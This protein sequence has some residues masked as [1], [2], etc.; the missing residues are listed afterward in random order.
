MAGLLKDGGT[1]VHE[2]PTVA[3]GRYFG[4]C[5]ATS[6]KRFI[7]DKCLIDT[8]KSYLYTHHMIASDFTKRHLVRLLPKNT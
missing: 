3:Y 6:A 2:E 5:T 1:A 8:A 4:C 7:Y